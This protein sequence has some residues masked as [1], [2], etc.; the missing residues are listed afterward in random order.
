MD[1]H[2]SRIEK[3]TVAKMIQAIFTQ[4]AKE[5]FI[6]IATQDEKGNPRTLVLGP[7]QQKDQG[8]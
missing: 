2:D 5:G 6:T 7:V 8:K 4:I 1:Q 3:D